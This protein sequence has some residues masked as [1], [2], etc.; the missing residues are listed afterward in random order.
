MEIDG[1]ELII[2]PASFQE[3]MDLKRAVAN[4]LTSRPGGL[5]LTGI[6]IDEKEPSKTDIPTDTILQTVMSVATD[7]EVIKHLF[8]CAKHAILEK[9]A[10]NKEFFEDVQH[11]GHFYQIMFEIVKVNLSPFFANLSSLFEGLKKKL[12]NFQ[13]SK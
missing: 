4:A 1:R 9:E 6:Q 13:T 12:T 2:T 7:P 11:R 5:G 8:I 3:A 10:I